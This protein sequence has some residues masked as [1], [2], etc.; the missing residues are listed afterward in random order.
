M[1][2]SVVTESPFNSKSIGWIMIIDMTG[3]VRGRTEEIR[4]PLADAPV[5]I[6]GR[7]KIYMTRIGPRTE[8]ENNTVTRVHVRMM[9]H[10]FG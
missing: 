5:S 8:G 6:R 2:I 9:S 3:A 4:E 1:T 10:R 7:Q